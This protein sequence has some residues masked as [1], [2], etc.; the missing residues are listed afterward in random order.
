MV[1]AS[2]EAAVVVEATLLKAAVVEAEVMKAAAVEAAVVKAAVVEATVVEVVEA[3][4]EDRSADSSTRSR[5]KSSRKHENGGVKRTSEFPY[6]GGWA[7]PPLPTLQKTGGESLVIHIIEY[8]VSGI[9]SSSSLNP[10]ISTAISPPLVPSNLS[11]KLGCTS[12]C[13][14]WYDVPGR[15]RIPTLVHNG[16]PSCAPSQRVLS[17]HTLLNFQYMTRIS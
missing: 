12:V 8:Q 6:S 9:N 16:I 3:A 5:A 15:Y 7:Y 17:T 14:T 13:T 2:V 11:P 4:V 10:S 1:Q